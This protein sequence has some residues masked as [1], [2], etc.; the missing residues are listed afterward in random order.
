[1]IIPGYYLKA[2]PIKKMAEVTFNGAGQLEHTYRLKNSGTFVTNDHT[3]IFYWVKKLQLERELNRTG[4][5]GIHVD[6]HEDMV[7]PS[8][9]PPQLNDRRSKRANLAAMWYYTRDNLRINNPFVPL[10]YDRSLD[11]L[12][13]LA[14]GKSRE[15]YR[16][17]RRTLIDGSPCIGFEDAKRP[18]KA[19]GAKNFFFQTLS[20][21]DVPSFLEALLKNSRRCDIKRRIFLSI[22][23]DRFALEGASSTNGS[24]QIYNN[25]DLERFLVCMK[26][27]K[28]RFGSMWTFICTSTEAY[29]RREPA[30]IILDRL[31]DKLAL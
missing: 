21:E 8:A 17:F 24:D 19:K 23:I 11:G 5:V 13:W 4:L 1:M 10:V 14:E 16:C 9:I 26:Q 15:H 2:V 31:G 20:F 12:I 22:D 18:S 7:N 25:E 3:V 30:R 28:E 27:V 6:A 29:I